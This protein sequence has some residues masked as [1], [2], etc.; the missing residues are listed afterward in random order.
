M[1]WTLNEMERS[2][3]TRDTFHNVA[4]LDC[5]PG[6]ISA[7]ITWFPWGMDSEFSPVRLQ[8]DT[9]LILWGCFFFVKF[10]FYF[11]VYLRLADGQY[12]I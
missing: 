7:C 10:I 5:K 8:I 2:G 4:E 11:Y 3:M 12:E 9:S 1:V 6:Y